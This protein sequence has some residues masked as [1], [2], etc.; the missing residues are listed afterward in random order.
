MGTEDKLI[1]K[2]QRKH[3]RPGEGE[4]GERLGNTRTTNEGL[5]RRE[6]RK[7]MVPT[8]CRGT[9]HLTIIQITFGRGIHLEIVSNHD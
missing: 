2:W 7:Y 6:P 3:G 1:L 8:G 4:K 5:P 9:R